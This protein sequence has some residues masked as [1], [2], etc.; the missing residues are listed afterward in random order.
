MSIQ[1]GD[2]LCGVHWIPNAKCFCVR[3]LS[4]VPSC[5]DPALLRKERRRIDHKRRTGTNLNERPVD[6]FNF[7]ID[8]PPPV[9]YVRLDMKCVKYVQILVYTTEYMVR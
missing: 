9:V 6:F 8:R 2:G 1:R 5:S 4:L 7:L 3:Y